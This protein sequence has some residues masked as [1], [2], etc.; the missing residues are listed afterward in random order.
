[1]HRIK[2]WAQIAV[3]AIVFALGFISIVNFSFDWEFI[4]PP[5]II[6]AAVLIVAGGTVFAN[7]L[8]TLDSPPKTSAGVGG[9]EDR[10][11]SNP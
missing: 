10:D 5:I 3:G 1:M 6:S 8:L 2:G 9:Q 11:S 7:G 4:V